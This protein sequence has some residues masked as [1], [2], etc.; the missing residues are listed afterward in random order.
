MIVDAQD[1]VVDDL[2]CVAVDNNPSKG[3]FFTDPGAGSVALFDAATGL[4]SFK[5]P[6]RSAAV[7]TSSFYEIGDA[8]GVRT[9]CNAPADC[10]DRVEPGLTCQLLVVSGRGGGWWHACDDGG[11]QAACAQRRECTGFACARRCAGWAVPV[12]V[13]ELHTCNLSLAGGQRRV[14]RLVR[15]AVWR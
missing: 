12:R 5:Q 14:L 7:S 3:S 8:V 1:S 10:G 11:W 2:M 6:A 13:C 9:L 4:H 15:G